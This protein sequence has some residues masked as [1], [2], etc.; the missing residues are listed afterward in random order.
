MKRTTIFILMLLV[1][2]IFIPIGAHA[3]LQLNGCYDSVAWIQPDGTILDTSNSDIYV[4][5]D[6]DKVDSVFP[7]G[8]ISATYSFHSWDEENN[9]L[10]F[11]IDDGTMVIYYNFS[12]KSI[13]MRDLSGEGDM[14]MYTNRSSNIGVCANGSYDCSKATDYKQE[15]NFDATIVF[16]EDTATITSPLLEGKGK[17]NYSYKTYDED[18]N[19]LL[20][21]SND[22]VNLYYFPNDD[23]F[24]MTDEE[25][26]MFMFE[27]D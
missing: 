9:R 10:E 11:L 1:I 17:S 22:G 14:Y 19:Y 27:G 26:Y 23:A 25:S 2:S 3:D 8:T 16:T 4:R 6:G 13:L 5:F 12:D 21:T 18:D 24:I 20:F 7:S 15:Y